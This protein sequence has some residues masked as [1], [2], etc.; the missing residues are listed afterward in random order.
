MINLTH[1]AIP[2]FLI[3]DDNMLI[4]RF[5]AAGS[6]ICVTKMLKLV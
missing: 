1:V 2:P 3:Y 5:S 4:D 6:T